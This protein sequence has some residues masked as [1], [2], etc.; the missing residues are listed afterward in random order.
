MQATQSLGSYL[1]GLREKRQDTEFMPEV[2]GAILEDSPWLSRVTVWAVSACLLTAMAWAHFAVLEEVTT[3]EGKAIPSSKIQ[4]I[5]NLEGGIVSEIFVREGQ[6]V[7]KGDTL[8]RLD[9]TRFL[10][11]RG[12]TEADRLALMARLERLGAEAEGREPSLPEEVLQGAPQLAE[13]ELALYRS[14]QQRLQSEQRTLGEQL[15][16][17]EQELAEFRSKAQQYRSSLG[18]LQQELNM[19]QP[20]VA[21]GAIS[22]VEVLRLRRSLVEVRGSLEATNLAIPRAEAAMSEIKSKMDESELSFRSDAFKELNEVRTELQKITATRV[23][24]EDKVTRTTVTSPV[25]G[26]IKQLKVNTIGGV[27]QPGSD[28]VEIVPLDDS[29]LIEAKV[30]PQDVAFLHPGQ[31]AMVKFTAYDYTIYG[32]LKANLELIS[33]DTITDEEG[34]SFYLIQVRTDKSHLGSEENPLLIIPGM[35]A[36]VDI[37]TGEKSVLSYLL[38]PVLKARSEAMRER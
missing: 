20:L 30:R 24:I 12:E 34:N 35:V 10:S 22:Q 15:R 4:V 19:S 18:L 26:V 7:D 11:N 23:A 28:M 14:R 32:G 21:S 9:D 1:D 33:A 36:T 8:L 6:V 38:K 17:K 29:L 2:E 25:R 37:I 27:V 13:D 31:K 16:Q 3:G 5:Q